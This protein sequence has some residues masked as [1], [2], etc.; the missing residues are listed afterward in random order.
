MWTL[1]HIIAISFSLYLKENLTYRTILTLFPLSKGLDIQV[2][3]LWNRTAVFGMHALQYRTS[4]LGDIV[5]LQGDTITEP[6]LTTEPQQLVNA[7]N[8]ASETANIPVLG[9]SSCGLSASGLTSKHWNSM[10]LS[11]YTQ[12]NKC[13]CMC[14]AHVSKQKHILI[15]ITNDNSAGFSFKCGS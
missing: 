12:H 4:V 6:Q 13:I 10:E 14:T 15:K 7:D 3:P 1:S 2:R 5:S 8:V 11:V 9:L